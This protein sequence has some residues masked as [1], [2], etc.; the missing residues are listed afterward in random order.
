METTETDL[1]DLAENAF[2][3]RPVFRPSN[4]VTKWI[5]PFNSERVSMKQA[6][7][8]RDGLEKGCYWC[9]KPFACLQDSTLEHI[10]AFADGGRHEID[11]CALAC[12]SC[13]STRKPDYVVRKEKEAQQKRLG[14]AARN[15][16]ANGDGGTGVDAP[17]PISL[18]ASV[19]IRFK[20]LYIARSGMPMKGTDAKRAFGNINASL[21]RNPPTRPEIQKFKEEFNK[22]ALRQSQK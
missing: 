21:F 7:A 19:T 12:E 4:S 8:D 13:N 11:N 5:R 6:V 1:I 14:I 3:I 22:W 9:G 18:D 20:S 15:K 17:L 2:P 10:L 16:A